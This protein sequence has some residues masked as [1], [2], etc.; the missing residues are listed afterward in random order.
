MAIPE[1]IYT[2]TIKHIE[3]TLFTHTDED[4]ENLLRVLFEQRQKKM[5]TYQ[6]YDVYI[7]DQ[8]GELIY[9]S[10]T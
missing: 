10:K 3:A 5:N 8:Y 7:R 2:G 1:K 6:T 9:G 4:L